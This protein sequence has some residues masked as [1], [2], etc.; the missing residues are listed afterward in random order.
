MQI[1]KERN[2][3]RAVL[4]FADDAALTLDASGLTA[5]DLTVSDVSSETHKIVS[6]NEPA[7]PLYWVA[8]ALAYDSGYWYVFD[9][10]TYD[11]FVAQ[12][13][14]LYEKKAHENAV[15]VQASIMAATQARLD[16][17]A[18]TRNYD[19]ILS[20]CTYATSTNPTFAK[21]GQ[22]GVNMRDATWA[23]LYEMLAEVEAG[24]RP[25]PTGYVDIE[26]E[27]PVL[28]WANIL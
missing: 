25:V 6:G 11:N 17:F 28:D 19:G 1:I 3:N 5:P 23:K 13:R 12:A 22:Y 21:E 20:L 26:A 14:A 4:M 18:R 24:I 7:L 15:R 10:V 8:G 2:T 16:D 27:L 9:Q